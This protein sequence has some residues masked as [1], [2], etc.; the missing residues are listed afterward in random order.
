MLSR[1]MVNM[2]LSVRYT[3]NA[4]IIASCSIYGQSKSDFTS[5]AASI[6]CIFFLDRLVDSP[7]IDVDV[8]GPLS[9]MF[10][11]LTQKRERA[12]VNE[13]YVWLIKRDPDRTLQVNISL[14]VPI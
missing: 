12:L 13:W 1:L 4:E 10:E 8:Q 6:W 11:L 5:C 2:M 3:N 9:K 14:V 7:G